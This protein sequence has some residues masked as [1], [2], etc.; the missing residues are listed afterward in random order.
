VEERPSIVNLDGETVNMVRIWVKKMS[1]G[2][3]CSPFRVED[4]GQNGQ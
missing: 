3:H 2:L 4:L 1:I